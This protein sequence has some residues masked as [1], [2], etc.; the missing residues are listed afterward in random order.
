MPYNLHGSALTLTADERAAEA[1]R[2][3]DILGRE[4]EEDLERRLSP[5]A[6]KFLRE[7]WVAAS[8]GGV[9]VAVSEQQLLWLRDLKSKFD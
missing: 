4:D 8:L 9:G 1:K 6:L 7:K 2:L 5:A 3:L